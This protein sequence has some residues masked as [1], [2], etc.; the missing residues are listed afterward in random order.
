MRRLPNFKVYI[1]LVAILLSGCAPVTYQTPF[2]EAPPT[3]VELVPPVPTFVSLGDC[4]MAYGPGAC[5]TGQISYQQVNLVPPPGAGS[6]YMPVAFGAMTGVLVNQFYSPPTVYISGYRYRDYLSYGYASHYRGLTAAGVNYYRNAPI[7][8]Q[9]SALI[10]GQPVRYTPSAR[11]VTAPAQ[12]PRPGAAPVTRPTAGTPPAAIPASG[13]APAGRPAPAAGAG[14]A[15][16]GAKTA[17]ATKP[18]NE[19]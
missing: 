10:N 16:T 6:W 1:A 5:G 12:A 19:K 17:P 11:P 9:R 18:R 7:W 3:E 15:P 2:G 4:E 8:V 13:A 14:S